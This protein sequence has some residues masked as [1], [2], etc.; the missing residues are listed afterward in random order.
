MQDRKIRAN[1]PCGP[2]RSSATRGSFR[3][4]N[5]PVDPISKV[6]GLAKVKTRKTGRRGVRNRTFA[7]H[8]DGNASKTERKANRP[9]P[10]RSLFYHGPRYL[11]VAIVGK[12]PPMRTL[13]LGIEGISNGRREG[14]KRSRLVINRRSQVASASSGNPITKSNCAWRVTTDGRP[15]PLLELGLFPVISYCAISS[16]PLHRLRSKR[17][18]ALRIRTSGSGR[19]MSSELE[20][21]GL[22]GYWS[23]RV[24]IAAPVERPP[25]GIHTSPTDQGA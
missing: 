1:R 15:L 17:T 12:S 10:T 4:L 19:P 2:R 6:R 8:L 20:L 9:E 5:S 23:K 24:I 18:R 25:L 14:T 7:L 22:H 3:T 21:P 16:D 13:M 11:Q